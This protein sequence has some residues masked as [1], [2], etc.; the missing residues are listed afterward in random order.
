MYFDTRKIT[1]CAGRSNTWLVERASF[2][3]IMNTVLV[4]YLLL[5]GYVIAS[6]QVPKHLAIVFV[7]GIGN[8]AIFF[9]AETKQLTEK[10]SHIASPDMNFEVHWLSAIVTIT[11]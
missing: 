1:G 3:S 8:H 5:V 11:L 10:T 9:C 2:H 7:F 6:R 4:L